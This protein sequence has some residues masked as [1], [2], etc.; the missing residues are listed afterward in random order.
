MVFL[1]SE[2]MLSASLGVSEKDLCFM[3]DENNPGDCSRFKE[4][5]MNGVGVFFLE[6]APRTYPRALL[7]LDS[8]DFRLAP[9]ESD[10][11][12]CDTIR[13]TAG[14]EGSSDSLLIFKLCS[15]WVG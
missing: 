1:F 12:R 13:S 9:I 8:A 5:S 7:G 3:S 14:S 11:D 4:D 15:D 6:T 10:L 2:R